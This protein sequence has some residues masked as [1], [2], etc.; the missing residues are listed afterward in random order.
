MGGGSGV[1]MPPGAKVQG[2]QNGACK[3][4]TRVKSRSVTSKIAPAAD[5][6]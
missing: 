5:I 1:H 3:N 2:R 6:V 4:F